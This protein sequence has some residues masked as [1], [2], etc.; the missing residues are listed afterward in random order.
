MV[1]TQE[2]EETEKLKG[3]K[4]TVIGPAEGL[5]LDA[6]PQIGQQAGPSE[7]RLEVRRSVPRDRRG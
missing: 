3:L 5:Q 6:F 4:M 2:A 1:R 7:V